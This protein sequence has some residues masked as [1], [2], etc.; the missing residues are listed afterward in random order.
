MDDRPSTP[1]SAAPS[2]RDITLAGRN[3]V[4]LPETPSRPRLQVDMAPQQQGGHR[5]S[6]MSSRSADLGSLSAHRYVI[7]LYLMIIVDI[8]FL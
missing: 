2:T 4:Y 3:S 1:P 6:V 7:V 8:T 5:Q